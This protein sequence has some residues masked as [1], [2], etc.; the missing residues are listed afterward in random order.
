[1]PP[2]SRVRGIVHQLEELARE[3]NIYELRRLHHKAFV[4]SLRRL[5]HVVYSWNTVVTMMS[6]EQKARPMARRLVEV[7]RSFFRGIV[8]RIHL[9][10]SGGLDGLPITDV[11]LAL[12]RVKAAEAGLEDGSVSGSDA[13]RQ[14]LHDL[15][16]GLQL[17]A[18]ASDGLVVGDVLKHDVGTIYGR[19]RP[20]F[21]VPPAWYTV[22]PR[23]ASP[24]SHV[25]AQLWDEAVQAALS[26]LGAFEE[27]FVCP[28]MPWTP[29]VAPIRISITPVAV[30]DHT[31][32]IISYEQ[33]CD[34]NR[35]QLRLVVEECGEV[36]QESTVPL[37]NPLIT[38]V[39]TFSLEQTK[40]GRPAPIFPAPEFEILLSDHASAVLEV[41][42]LVPTYQPVPIWSRDVSPPTCKMSCAARGKLLLGQVLPPVPSLVHPL[43][44]TRLAL[45]AQNSSATMEVV[46]RC[47]TCAVWRREWRRSLIAKLRCARER[48]ER[49][50]MA[51]EERHTRAANE[52]KQLSL[53]DFDAWLFEESGH[54]RPFLP[55]R[56]QITDVAK[57]PLKIP[58]NTEVPRLKGHSINATDGL[59][60]VCGGVLPG[61]GYN[62][63]LFEVNLRNLQLR[64]VSSMSPI[65]RQGQSVVTYRG[66]LYVYGGYG[67]ALTELAGSGT[68]TVP[69]TPKHIAEPTSPAPAPP[70]RVKKGFKK[71]SA[72]SI[73]YGAKRRDPQKAKPKGGAKPGPGGKLGGS[74]GSSSRP[75]VKKVFEGGT[76]LY[77][78]VHEY[79]VAAERWTEMPTT[80]KDP[81]VLLNRAWHSSVVVGHRM[82]VFGGLVA[83][84]WGTE[85]ETNS[86][87]TLSLRSGRWG[88][89]SPTGLVPTPRYGHTA[90]VLEGMILVYGGAGKVEATVGGADVADCESWSSLEGEGTE[91]SRYLEAKRDIPP[92]VP[93]VRIFAEL[94]EYADSR[95][96]RV[97]PQTSVSPPPLVHHTCA[98]VDGTM[99]VIGGITSQTLDVPCYQ[100][101][102]LTR[103]WR[104]VT[105]PNSRLV[106]PLRRSGLCGVLFR[107]HTAEATRDDA[108]S[109]ASTVSLPEEYEPDNSTSP[110]SLL[111][112]GGAVCDKEGCARVQIEASSLS[113]ERAV[114][115]CGGV[116]SGVNVIRLRPMI[117]DGEEK[118][119]HD[120]LYPLTGFRY[121]ENRRMIK[122][123]ARY[124]FK[125]HTSEKRT[126]VVNVT[127]SSKTP[128]ALE[129]VGITLGERNTIV[130]IK[131]DSMAFHA[132]LTRGMRLFA[133]NGKAIKVDKDAKGVLGGARGRLAL[134]FRRPK[135][136][137]QLS[138]SALRSLSRS[139]S[140]DPDTSLN[141]KGLVPWIVGTRRV[142]IDKSIPPVGLHLRDHHLPKQAIERATLRLYSPKEP[143]DI[144]SFAAS[145]VPSTKLTTEQQEELVSRLSSP[146][147]VRPETK[148]EES[149][150]YH[151]FRDTK[152]SKKDLVKAVER[153]RR[154][155]ADAVEAVPPPSLPPQPEQ[156][157]K[158]AKREARR[159]PPSPPPSPPGAERPTLEEHPEPD[160]P[161]T[162]PKVIQSKTSFSPCRQRRVEPSP[163]PP[164]PP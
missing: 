106:P 42:V 155:V 118:E 158:S 143:T 2:A 18:S 17:L 77:S 147:R 75:R 108:E 124:W 19:I 123:Y 9:G 132:G 142:S 3:D 46:L 71:K 31:M 159:A 163:P 65:Q 119:L 28:P 15:T 39:D 153:L 34:P 135:S 33:W 104:L 7:V 76:R 131:K 99:F 113:A 156:R 97:E 66:C 137:S 125:K 82:H 40:S 12:E 51:E 13:A 41:Q 74:F 94:W 25:S 59:A 103:S 44:L 162:P 146:P 95:W 111:I 27:P 136:E 47:N 50:R 127:V 79:D 58:A 100:Y 62:R 52:T 78:A 150:A 102:A 53:H 128:S 110:L 87:V 68:I 161:V 45:R 6:L 148:A 60:Y 89:V 8:A 29:P 35:V 112:F 144:D 109:T 5:V 138:E 116:L 56:W 48:T 57:H 80:V 157:R 4:A 160:S 36:V 115:N 30:F 151:R 37:S 96:E 130:S 49:R 24:A 72:V 121:R 107:K 69:T 117:P 105:C 85:E 20:Q 86:M 67:P 141:S 152:L 38:D 90:C 88:L 64:V 83:T 114:D 149:S 70:H 55:P 129:A 91:W 133:V 134:A 139:P 32:E 16:R 81:G 22:V 11:F 120:E 63:D 92:P 126:A 43:H 54:E 73:L 26:L 164:P 21:K 145:L 101:L 23:G 1:M 154:R 61:G 10:K 122:K 140:P 98:V 14:V 84:R 93:T